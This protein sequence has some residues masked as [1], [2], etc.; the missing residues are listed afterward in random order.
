[1][2]KKSNRRFL[3]FGIGFATYCVMK[4]AACNNTEPE[5]PD[6]NNPYINPEKK[7]SKPHSIYEEKVKPALDQIL[8]FGGLIV[9]APL[10]AAISLA[11][12][13]DDPGKIIFTQKRIGK[14]KKFFM[15][16]K[17]RSMKTDTPHD[18]PTHQFEHPEQ[19]ITRVGR[20]LRKTSLDEIPQIWDIFRGKMSIIG[21]R[22]ALWNQKDLVEERDKWNANSV[23]PG[24]T[25]LAQIKGRDK[26][27]ISD[28]AKLD[29]DYTKILRRGGWTAFGQDIT[30]FIGTIGSVLR[31][32]G[33]VEGGT[34]RN[35]D[36]SADSEDIGIKEYGYRKT[37][38]IDTNRKKR[39]IITGANSYIGE[40]LVQWVKEHYPGIEIFTVDMR[41]DA[42]REKDFRGYDAVF[43]VAGI[44]HA[45]VG[46]ISEEE[47]RR[48]Y[49]V[50][51]ELAIE[52][53]K[54]AK[55]SGVKQFILMSSMIIYG[56]S[57][58]YGKKKMIDQD[59]V[60]SPVNFYGDSKWQA[61][62]GVRKLADASFA[63]AVIRAPMVY[64]R[65]A[66]G[67]YPI[68][69][70]LAKKLPVFPDVDNQRSMLHIDNLCEFLSLLILSGE[71]GIYFPQN[72]EYTKTAEM[73]KYISL[74][75]GK[76]MWN[77]K[78]LNPVIIA[79]SHIPGKISGTVNKAF[80]NCVYDQKLSVYE[81]LEYRIHTLK[82]SV[83]VTESKNTDK[84]DR[85]QKTVL[86]VASVASM[87]D[88]FNIPNIKLLISMGYQVD[89][90]TNFI[91][92]STCTDEKIKE[93]LKFLDELKVDCYQIDFNRK[94]TDIRADVRAMRQLDHVMRGTERPVNITRYHRINSITPYTFV[95]AHSPIGGVIGR[96][97][98]KKY[99]I[100]V[101]YTA[102]GFH[103]YD[104]APKKNWLIYY[105]IEKELSRITDVLITINKEDYRR[106]KACF[107][108]K[109]TVYIPGVGVD[110]EKF[111]SG[112]IDS[113]EKRKEMGIGE[114][115]ILI[116]SVGELTAR[117][118]IEIVIKA[119]AQLNNNSIQ[120]LIAGKGE[121]EKELK[122]LVRSLGLE[123]QVHFLGFRTD[124]AELC[125]AAD[126]FIF[127]SRQ[128]GMPLA[129]ME[130]IACKTPVVCSRIR[131]NT[132]LV[133]GE[134]YLFDENNVDDVVRILQPLVVSRNNIRALTANAV[135]SN[136][137]AL[138]SCD[139]KSVERR[140]KKEFEML[141]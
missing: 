107:H 104:G 100:P 123:E 22:P 19:Y 128:E 25:G 32:D 49:A 20:I 27:A 89:V 93:L 131:G 140:M 33:I 16:H 115:T 38:R 98:A 132:D 67:N 78:I 18:V 31:H 65:G 139:I 39:A 14:D 94:A 29:G 60:P 134:E 129:L 26:L 66:K 74:T 101:I 118:N 137:S 1:M 13:I 80:G 91:Y 63:V 130:A 112:V 106:A 45:D 51:T 42:W 96:I 75:A 54:K 48:Y 15:L 24:L 114:D 109:K 2:T 86:I 64:G 117:K 9:L 127:P 87:I 70:K 11:I 21:P 40:S 46:R 121:K 82:E 73:V 5:N 79:A 58:P 35:Q 61:D 69:S 50:N 133:K 138:R 81:G 4:A 68:L 84:I 7:V 8:S 110:T 136:I 44:A 72:A 92:G 97:I 36:I 124:I 62:K 23:M 95:H 57:A 34:G 88:Q 28:K 3:L 103:F 76:R 52:T 141:K 90:A 102:H 125:Q 111:K 119:L 59:T 120:Y 83:A 12:Y 43:H 116:L 126:I 105:P 113:G 122:A 85:R 41:N 77:R 55:A 6:E 71:G 99:E 56:D 30:C 108:A 37:F 53:A 47:K 10:Y 135:A 17:F